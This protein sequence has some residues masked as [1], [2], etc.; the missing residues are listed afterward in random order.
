MK[1]TGK[2][3]KVRPFDAMNPRPYTNYKH[4]AKAASEF[5]KPAKGS[6]VKHFSKATI[7]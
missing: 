5:Y 3:F 1:S 6:P 4:L 2:T 7:A